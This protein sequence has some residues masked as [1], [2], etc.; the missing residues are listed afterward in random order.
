[1][2]SAFSLCPAPLSLLQP[3]CSS[4]EG[5]SSVEPREGGCSFYKAAQ[6]DI[7]HKNQGEGREE[8]PNKPVLQARS[9]YLT[10]SYSIIRKGGRRGKFKS[11]IKA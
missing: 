4:K 9:S 3:L 7:F 11:W 8:S 10:S 1:M 6:Q 2:D 5:V